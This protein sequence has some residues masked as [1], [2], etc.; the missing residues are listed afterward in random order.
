[1]IVGEKFM[2]KIEQ[3]F[4]EAFGIGKTG[5]KTCTYGSK[6]WQDCKNEMGVGCPEQKYNYPPI[7]SEIVLGLEEI[8]TRQYELLLSRCGD[9]ADYEYTLFDYEYSEII[10]HFIDND[11]KIALLSLCTSVLS[12]NRI[13]DQVK[14]LFKC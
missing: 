13:Q 2:N 3:E 1:M 5:C 9:D 6:K 11:R 8:I 12:N 4:F 14:A 7:T 10:K